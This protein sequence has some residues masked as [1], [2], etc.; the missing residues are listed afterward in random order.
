MLY[1]VEGAEALFTALPLVLSEDDYIA[2]LDAPE[3]G[4]SLTSTGG[5]V[6]VEPTSSTTVLDP[7]GTCPNLLPTRISANTSAQVTPGASNRLRSDPSI[8]GSVL[9]QIPGG[10]QI[11]V[12]DGPVCDDANGI[13]WWQVEYNGQSGWTAESLGDSYFVE[14][15][16]AG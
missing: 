3:L 1:T 14:P 11:S 2:V 4:T 12:L 16:G 10:A 15:V 9:G 6:T 13:V 7:T 5:L 8:D